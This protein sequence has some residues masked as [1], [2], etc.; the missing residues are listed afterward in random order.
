MKKTIVL[1][2]LLCA[3]Q[4]HAQT[5]PDFQ[6]LSTA[7]GLSQGMVF[8]ILQSRDGFIWIATKD[9]LNRYDGSRFKV[10][11][12]DPFDPYSIANS[13]VRSIFEDSRGWIWVAFQSELDV[14]DSESGRFYHVLHDGNKNFGAEHSNGS[15]SMA[16]TPDG[17]IWFWGPDGIWKINAPN[18]LLAKAAKNGSSTIEPSCKMIPKPPVVAWEG[19]GLS[20][21]LV[22]AG[23]LLI[24][25]SD[26]LFLLDP[27]TEQILPEIS[28]PGWAFNEISADDEGRIIASTY[29][30]ASY[31]MKLALITRAGTQGPIAP[32][33]TGRIA[34]SP[35]GF[36]WAERGKRIQKWQVSSFFN[37]GKPD[38]EIEME[39]IFGSFEGGVNKFFFD[40]SGVTWVGTGGYGLLKINP[41][42]QN[43]KSY[44][45]QRSQR[46]LLEAPDGG[47]FSMFR[48]NEKYPSK[49]FQSVTSHTGFYNSNPAI[50]N[51]NDWGSFSACFDAAGNGWSSNK[52]AHILYRKDALTKSVKSFPWPAGY[53]LMVDRSGALLSAG[54]RGLTKF[55]PKTETSAEFPYDKPQNVATI[56]SCFLFE[57]VDGAIW[58]FGFE[59]LTKAVPDASGYH[60]KYFK[61][62]P[63]DRNSL[64]SNIVLSV[65]DDPLEP[66]RYLWVGTKSGG[67]NRLDKKTGQ[68]RQYKTE[69]GLP[70]NVVYGVLAENPPPSGVN[71]GGFI[72]LSTNKGLCRFDVR[73][74]TSKNFTV[75]DGL[76]DNEF[77]SS[78]YLKTR[79]GTMIFGGVKGLTVF[80]PD[81]LR[82]N[83]HL[84]QTHIVGLQVNNQPF[85]IWG[86]SSIT[87]SHNQNLL[88]FEFAALEFT[89]PA[90]NQYR[91]QLVGVDKGWVALGD[92]NSIQFANLAPGDYTLKVQ[93]SNNDG[94]WSEQGAELGFTI[95][96][97]WWN[98]WWAYAIY[99]ALAVAGIWWYYQYLLRQR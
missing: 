52:D 99:L 8:D 86:K 79:D 36:L 24:A 30:R 76:Q 15:P 25:T 32:F 90:Q 29:N 5:R 37:Q 43:F 55:D 50:D 23:K 13:E 85:D 38:L 9:G 93:S 83:E 21:F 96:P 72:W 11:S 33:W 97:P 98:S 26:G 44:L 45:P 12:P 56:F 19:L 10:F 71:R 17:V 4:L 74:E 64:S 20:K 88:T 31:Q 51:S 60:F 59:G 89:N 16:E 62:N 80:H 18:D 95:R 7:D 39:P 35:D 22:R 70:D 63:A 67:L 82:F 81:S 41:K 42:A 2:L 84:P 46:Q 48:P 40:K 92:K 75:A 28:T 14:F 66:H 3:C 47:I 54:E 1:F 34:F 58:I 68:F 6:L 57:D 87:L 78:S 49:A 77:N 27:S 61:I 65:A 73:A 69:Q 91:Y 94:V 53:G